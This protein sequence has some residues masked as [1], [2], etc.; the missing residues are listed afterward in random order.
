MFFIAVLAWLTASESASSESLRIPWMSEVIPL[1]C[2]A[3][4]CAAVRAPY[5]AVVESGEVESDCSA[6]VKSFEDGL[7]RIVVAGLTQDALEPLK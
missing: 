6:V 7:E 2:C 5:R 4:V 3:S 1:R